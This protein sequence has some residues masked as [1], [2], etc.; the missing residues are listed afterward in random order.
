MS[1]T[2]VLVVGAR[3]YSLGG[4]LL[5]ALEARGYEA[6]AAGITGEAHHL[7]L[8]VDGMPRIR[9]VLELVGPQHVFCTMGMN[10]VDFGALD[11]FEWYRV[12]LEANVIGPMRL[13]AAWRAV[14]A[15]ATTSSALHHYVAV[16]SNSATVPRQGSAAYCASK[17][18]LSQA[19]RCAAREESG[20]D[21][22]GLVVYGYE[23][24]LLA[25]TPM[26]ERTA[27]QLPGVPL[28]RMRG[29]RLSEGVP[30]GALADLMVTG[31]TMGASLNGVLV[32][33]DG[34]ER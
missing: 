3:P 33:F 14:L 17:A 11:P 34:G 5:T 28:T 24:G 31:L 22:R 19:L 12:H 6:V 23:P 2:R 26:T 27:E 16:S 30:P 29:W 8:V 20:G 1:G 32:P 25:G 13:L 21:A 10:L 4:A 15:E 9:E 18:A 7:D